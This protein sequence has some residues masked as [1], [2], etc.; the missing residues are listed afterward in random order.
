MMIMDKDR[1]ETEAFIITYD[2]LFLFSQLTR[3]QEE[4]SG[5]GLLKR[6]KDFGCC[7]SKHLF[8]VI[9]YYNHNDMKRS[10][11]TTRAAKNFKEKE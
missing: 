11:R 10:D 4:D 5:S 3:R 2:E 1:S 9:K 7:V 6:G 8:S